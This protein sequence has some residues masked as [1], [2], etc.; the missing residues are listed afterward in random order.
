MY[1]L[2]AKVRGLPNQLGWLLV[3]GQLKRWVSINDVMVECRRVR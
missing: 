3:G 1:K 2:G